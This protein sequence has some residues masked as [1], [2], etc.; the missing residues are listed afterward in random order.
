[1][2][3]VMAVITGGYV[4]FKIGRTNFDT[5]SLSPTPAL[6][7]I[8]VAISVAVLTGFSLISYIVSVAIY[9]KEHS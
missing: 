7:V 1:M 6:T 4:F 9:S 2:V 8:L 5:F 3:I